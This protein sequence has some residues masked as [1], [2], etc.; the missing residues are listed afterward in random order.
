MQPIQPNRLAS[1]ARVVGAAVAAS[2][3]IAGGSMA[4][5]EATAGESVSASGAKNDMVFAAGKNADVAVS[6]SDDV[7]VAAKSVR[8]NQAGADHVFAAGEDVTYA[9]VD[10]ED[11]LTAGKTVRFETGQAKDDVLA[12]GERVMLKPTFKVGGSAVLTGRVVEVEAPVGAELRAAGETVRIDSAVTGDVKVEAD[13]VVIGPNARIGGNLSYRTDDLKIDPKAVIT[14]TKTVMPASERHRGKH[15]EPQSLQ[16]RLV[17]LAFSIFMTGVLMIGAVLLFP[18]LMERS[19]RMLGRNPLLAALAG[20]GLALVVPI[21]AVVLAITIVGAPV[22]LLLILLFGAGLL[23]AFATTAASL[24]LLLRR[25][26]GKP[27]AAGLGARI[28]WGLLG[29]VLLCGLGAI[30]VAGGWITLAACILGLGAVLLQGRSG[31][32]ARAA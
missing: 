30:P 2:L 18:G 3:L 9:G 21:L 24:G 16:D 31:L 26:T 13:H 15:H 11:I 28:G 1:L 14:G 12:F 7:F 6:T 19:G 5:P 23:L 10:A 29:V 20:V 17:D 32:A 22:A 4:A 27:D 8:I 25:V